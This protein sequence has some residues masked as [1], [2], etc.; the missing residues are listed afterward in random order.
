MVSTLALLLIVIIPLVLFVWLL[1][2]ESVAAYQSAQGWLQDIKNNGGISLD[3]TFPDSVKSIWVK[4]EKLLARWDIVPQDI[5]LNN[6]N[7]IGKNIST[8]GAVV[9][10]NMT[11]LI[12]DG[13]VMVFTL[14]FFLRDGEKIARKIVDLIPMELSYKEHILERLEQTLS[15]IVRGFFITAAA[16]GLLAGFGY[17]ITGLRFSV[18]LGFLTAFSALIPFAGAAA[19][20]IPASLYLLFKGSVVKCIIL[21]LWGVL[22][23]SLIDNFLKPVLIGDK[24]KIPMFLLFFALF[25]GLRVYGF[26]GVLVGPLIITTILAFIKI[27]EEQFYRSPGNV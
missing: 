12:F 5:F 1:I 25:G 26:I 14:F 27:Y 8:L 6:I 9:V 13:I 23:V 16:Q 18:L 2:K 7:Q 10:K 20:W 19:V 24:A 17:A 21:A 3:S 15:A 22:V 4:T 11:M